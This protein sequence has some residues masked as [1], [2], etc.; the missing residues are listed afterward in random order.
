MDSPR[1]KPTYSK[2][3]ATEAN[4]LIAHWSR[5]DWREVLTAPNLCVIQA[6]TLDGA[7]ASGAGETREDALAC[8]L[9]ETAEIVALATLR[10]AGKAAIARAYSGVAAHS[11]NQ[12]ALRLAIFEAHERTAVWAW[13]LGQL[14]AQKVT[15][16]WLHKQGITQWLKRARRGSMLRRHTDVW[17][18][19]YPGPVTV[20]VGRSQGTVAQDPIL[21]FGADS[22]PV[23][24]VRKALRETLLMEIN[25]GEVLAS[26]SGY[27][28]Q[29]TRLIE[30]KIANYAE[31]CP[32]LLGDDS[33]I[34]PRDSQTAVDQITEEG[35]MLQ[36]I[37]PAGQ[38]R[39][40]W[41][42]HLPN[43]QN[44]GSGGENSPFM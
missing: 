6:L 10:D 7:T 13:W 33:L 39:R 34:E 16:D 41:R 17:L 2:A 12:K 4:Q 25:L 23:Q 15:A 32:T 8:C 21:G 42:C 24:A 11:T 22:E 26:R 18:L 37:T 9:G 30:E 3:V 31:R 40:V 43:S 29:E 38:L 35:L 27:S 44:Y 1:T 20:A 19:D 5:H 28:V 14:A 36:D